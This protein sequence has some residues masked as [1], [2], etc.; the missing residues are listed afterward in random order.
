MA[1]WISPT[2]FFYEALA[3]GE[4]RCLPEQ[5]GFTISEDATQRATNSSAFFVVGYA[6]HDPTATEFSCEGWYWG[7]LP[8]LLVGLTIRYAAAGAMH[9]FNRAQQTKKPLLCMCKKNKR[10]FVM[11]F[12][13]MIT[14]GGLISVTTWLFTKDKPYE[15]IT[16]DEILGDYVFG[17]L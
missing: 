15:D 3:V 2:R 4:Y 9:G 14:L 17:N 12:T 5:S 11:V 1:G 7:V 16:I 6:G 10:I 8:S 13:Y